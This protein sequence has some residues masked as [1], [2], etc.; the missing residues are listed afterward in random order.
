MSKNKAQKSRSLNRSG[1][2]LFTRVSTLSRGSNSKSLPF[3]PQR[4]VELLTSTPFLSSR[5]VARQRPSL[6]RP[7]VAAPSNFSLPF[8]KKDAKLLNEAMVC[9]RRSVRREVIFASGVGG[10]RGLRGPHYSQTSNVRCAK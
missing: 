1:R 3:I 4:R 5:P 9:A 7:R 2:D 8:S 10:S 6:N